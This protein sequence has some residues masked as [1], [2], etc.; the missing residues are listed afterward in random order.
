MLKEN[1]PL[2]TSGAR[3]TGADDALIM[4]RDDARFS[5]RV[6][7]PGGLGRESDSLQPHVARSSR[8]PLPTD[9]LPVRQRNRLCP[10]DCANRD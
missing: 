4:T 1:S 5:Q 9:R 10:K 8:A 3:H 7:L 2:S 6:T